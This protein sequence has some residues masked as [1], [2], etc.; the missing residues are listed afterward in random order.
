MWNLVEVI[1]KHGHMTQDET[2]YV[3][4]RHSELVVLKLNCLC[5]VYSD[6]CK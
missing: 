5:P 3:W 2:R 1:L 4:N 6:K